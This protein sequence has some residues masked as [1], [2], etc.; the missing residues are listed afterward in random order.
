[1]LL[2][3]PLIRV[4]AQSPKL[5]PFQGRLADASGKPIPD[6]VRLIQFRIFDSAAGGN[7]VWPPGELHRTTVNGGLINVVLGSKSPFTGV[8]FNRTLYLDIVADA[9]GDGQITTD[10][11]PLQPRQAIL[12]VIFAAESADSRKLGGYDWSAIFGANNP[13]GKIDGARIANLTSNSIALETINASLISPGAINSPQISDGAITLP[14][15][16]ERTVGPIAPLGGIAIS[17]PVSVSSNVY[18]LGLVE[19]PGL[20]V[21]LVT[22]GRPVMVTLVPGTPPQPFANPLNPTAA[23][24]RVGLEHN[25]EPP[26]T[27]GASA[28][29]A[30]YRNGTNLVSLDRIRSGNYSVADRGID[31]P[32]GSLKALDL[33]A[34]SRTNTYSIQ[35]GCDDYRDNAVLWNV[36]LVA[37][38]L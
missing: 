7:S 3:A 22:S 33:E 12:P 32:A 21:S 30:I 14:K 34:G 17:R 35:F 19:V 29:F 9:N 37:Y 2:S 26:G 10:D 8:D 18:N 5:L 20:S 23:A 15:L 27:S 1:M 6:G 36:R 16:A 13:L 28:F 31:V 11:P 4:Q 25:S 24:S 38:E